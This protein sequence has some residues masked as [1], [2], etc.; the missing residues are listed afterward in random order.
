MFKRYLLPTT[1]M[2]LMAGACQ[3]DFSRKNAAPD[4]SHLDVPFRLLRFDQDVFAL[5]TT[6]LEE[7]MRRLSDKYP[8]L[9]TLFTETLIRDQTNPNETPQQALKAFL[10]APLTRALYD[11]V[12]L[13]YGD[14]RRLEPQLHNMM[15]YFRYYF[16]DRPTPA[17]TTIISEFGVDAFTYGDSLC[18]I[19]LDMF[20]GAESAYYD[21]PEIFPVYLRRNF[22]EPHIPARLARTIAQHVVG[23]PPS[24]GRLIDYMLHNG[25]VLHITSSLLPTVPDSLIMGYTRE[26]L[27]GCVANEAQV[28]ARLLDQN[29]IYHADYNKFRKLVEPSPN[30]P[31]V[32]TEAPGEI[33]NWVGWQIVR[34]YMERHPETSMS[35]LI[36]PIEAQKFL[37]ESRYK[38][39]KL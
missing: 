2:L 21:V 35:T 1:L 25:K 27:S 18:G 33:G 39:R 32:F 38:P 7:E 22:T 29:L 28:W 37:E 10:T 26:Q 17:I 31:I 34:S 13:K 11:S 16:P 6:N 19:G 30:A 36:Q 12:Q 5:D 23:P 4:V 24:G 8:D 9:I 15:R 3:K 20:L 14:L